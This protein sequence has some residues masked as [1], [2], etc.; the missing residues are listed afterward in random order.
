VPVVA[1]TVDTP[2]LLA[3]LMRAGVDAVVT[4]DPAIFTVTLSS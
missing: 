4:N 2:E 1:W 3:R